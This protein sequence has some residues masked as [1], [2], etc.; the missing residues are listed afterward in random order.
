[1]TPPAP[2]PAPKLK[3]TPQESDFLKEIREKTK[4]TAAAN[5]IKAEKQ[6]IEQ[7]ERQRQISEAIPQAYRDYARN[8]ITKAASQ[9]GFSTTTVHFCRYY[10]AARVDEGFLRQVAEEISDELAV[11]GF[12]ARVSEID[13]FDQNHYASQDQYTDYGGIQGVP[14]LRM[15]INW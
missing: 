3:P 8:E 12:E 2:E 10:D 1:V 5:A 13:Q 7:E 11:E 15:I 4:T 9:Y 14:I 6:K